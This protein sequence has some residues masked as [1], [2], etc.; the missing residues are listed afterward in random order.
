M[1]LV[2]VETTIPVG[3]PSAGVDVTIQPI[4]VQVVASVA[5][6]EMVFMV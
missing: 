4:A 1:G 6:R 2:P 5:Q 3:C